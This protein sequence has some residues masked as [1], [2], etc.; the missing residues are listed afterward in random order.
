MSATTVRVGLLAFALL[1][2]RPIAMVAEGQT[3]PEP[4]LLRDKEVPR[5]TGMSNEDLPAVYPYLPE[6]AK[7]TGAAILVC[8]GG[9]NQTRCVDFEGV[10]IANWFRDRGIA[11]FI[12]RYRI[13]PL[14]S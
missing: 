8:P 4:F 3:I 9:G 2:S 7:N 13:A 12:L 6:A 14:Y 10:L 1:I 11:V 5:A